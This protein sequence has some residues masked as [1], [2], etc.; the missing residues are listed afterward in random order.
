M[1]WPSEPPETA[2]LSFHSSGPT[3]VETPSSGTVLTKTWLI[4]PAMGLLH[5]ELDVDDLADDAVLG[6]G[7]RVGQLDGRGGDYA[8][9]A[10]PDDRDQRDPSGRSEGA[11]LVLLPELSHYAFPLSRL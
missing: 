11:H 3:S 7:G 1:A 6:R 9:R 2:R 8:A 10:L 5:L 4:A